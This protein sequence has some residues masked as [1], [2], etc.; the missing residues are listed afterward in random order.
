MATFLEIAAYS[1]DHMFSSSFSPFVIQDISR[2]GFEG[3]I[4]VLIALIPGHC[5]LVSFSSPH[6]CFI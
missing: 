3:S 6:H 2:F 5:L 1:V 4:S